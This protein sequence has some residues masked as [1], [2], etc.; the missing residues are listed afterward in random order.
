MFEL[1]VGG[2]YSV[3]GYQAASDQST[4]TGGFSPTAH[5]GYALYFCPW[6]GIGVGVDW[7]LYSGAVRT[8]GE[9]IWDGV[10]DTDGE[11]YQH[12][13][14]V[15]K[16]Q[17][18]H[19]LHYLEVPLSLRFRVPGK[20]VRWIGE[21]G[22]KWG[23]PIGG[24][25]RGGGSLTHYGYYQPWDLTLR[26]QAD[27]GFYTETDYHPTDKVEGLRPKWSAF[28]KTGV[29]VPLA[30]MFELA[31]QVYGQ[32]NFTTLLETGGEAQ[33]GFR[34]DRVGMAEAHYFMQSYGP[35]LQSPYVK[36]AVRP[37][38]AGV[39]ISLRYTIPH[40]S[41]NCYPCM[42]WVY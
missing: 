17:E 2:G 19:S 13:L 12:H 30:A 9:Q 15:D 20:S 1:G 18:K 5:V 25:Y 35:M 8:S 7:T 40:P 37:W 10:T 4:V 28:A 21:V 27:H 24:N 23:Y 41:R 11:K 36:G 6:V 31:V 14:L 38:T 26:D 32:Y 16:W 3:L 34:D 33:T 42:M 29:A 39:E 22:A